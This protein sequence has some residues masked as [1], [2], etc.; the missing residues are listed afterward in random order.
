MGRGTQDTEGEKGLCEAT[1]E[2]SIYKQRREDQK[3]LPLLEEQNIE[4]MV[5]GVYTES[6]GLLL[7]YLKPVKG[8]IV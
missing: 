2:G 1:G 5:G 4:R 6:H 3:K 8:K 7:K